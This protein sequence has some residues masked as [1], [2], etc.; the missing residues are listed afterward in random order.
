[1]FLAKACITVGAVVLSTTVSKQQAKKEFCRMMP[2]F[3]LLVQCKREWGW[4]SASE[5]APVRA[6]SLVTCF[7]PHNFLGVFVLPA[8]ASS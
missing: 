4:S 1:M 6:N 8:A 7:K 2:S 3:Q 5:G